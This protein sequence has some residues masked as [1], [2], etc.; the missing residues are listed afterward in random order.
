MC[1]ILP[2]TKKKGRDLDLEIVR[3]NQQGVDI[4][5]K[6]KFFPQSVPEMLR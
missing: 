3:S 4:C 6:F 5:A 1:K 2:F